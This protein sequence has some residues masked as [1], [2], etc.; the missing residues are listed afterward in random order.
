MEGYHKQPNKPIRD[1]II[2]TLVRQKKTQITKYEAKLIQ[3]IMHEPKISQMGNLFAL[4]LYFISS[5][6]YLLLL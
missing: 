5:V 4:G 6:L 3:Q 2:K 1:L